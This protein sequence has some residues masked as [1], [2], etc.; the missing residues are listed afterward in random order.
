MSDS[1]SSTTSGHWSGSSGVSTPSP[2]HPQASPK[3]L[4]DAFGSPQTDNGFETDPD[5]FLLDEP[6]PRNRK[7]RGLSFQAQ[8][9]RG[10]A[11]FPRPSRAL[12]CFSDP[13]KKN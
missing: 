8:L 9:Q 12:S 7:V 1:G 10:Q 6:A 3:Y 4:G 5:A 13:F 2:P 11:W